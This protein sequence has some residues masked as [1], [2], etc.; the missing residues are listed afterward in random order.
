MRLAGVMAEIT[1]CRD[2]AAS[3][4][5]EIG[6]AGVAAMRG[7]GRQVAADLAAAA[8]WGLRLAERARAEEARAMELEAE[9]E[10]IRPCLARASG[11][12][13]AAEAMA[14]NARVEERRLA[15]VR[16]EAVVIT[17]ASAPAQVLDH[18]ASSGSKP[19]EISAGSPG[20]A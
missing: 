20:I 5:G 15:A 13:S 9:A 8:R 18:P 3:L 2:R 12:E 19:G 4:R 14:E 1:A 7:D 10:A 17:P 11:R 16:A 6:I